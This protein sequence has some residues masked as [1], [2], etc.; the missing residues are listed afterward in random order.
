MCQLSLINTDDMDM[1]YLL[2]VNLMMENS[3]T[4]N[5]DGSGIFLPGVG[6]SK[7]QNA[8]SE[9]LNLGDA[10]IGSVRLAKIKEPVPMLCHVRAASFSLT[11]KL[12]TE[13]HAHPF[14]SEHFVFAHNGTLTFKSVTDE[15]RYKDKELIDSEIFLAELELK[16]TGD[17]VADVNSTMD[18]FTGKFAFIIYHKPEAQFYVIRG[19]S[20]TLFQKRLLNDKTK[21]VKGLVI[22]TENLSLHDAC[23]RASNCYQLWGDRYDPEKAELLE[24]ETAYKLD[25]FSLVEVGKVKEN[26]K[27]VVTNFYRGGY[28]QTAH[29]EVRTTTATVTSVIEYMKSWGIGPVDM[30]EICKKVLGYGLIDMEYANKI[31]FTKFLTDLNVRY[32]P[33]FKESWKDMITSSYRYSLYL[34]FPELQF[35]YFLTEPSKF[36]EIYAQFIAMRKEEYENNNLQ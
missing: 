11:K 24:A 17:V 31:V 26:E 2:A 12:I 29:G 5:K 34:L 22:N 15:N 27:P 33:S 16:Y 20:A 21:E 23:L 13:E 18:L 25:G 19:K 30:D 32:V 6:V 1:T 9:L 10:V 14:E 36:K 4:S 3:R 7:T 8:S 28:S 35:P